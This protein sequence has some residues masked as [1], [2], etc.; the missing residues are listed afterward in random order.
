MEFKQTRIPIGKLSLNSG[1]IEGLPANPRQWKKD[2]ITRTAKS[3]QETPELFEMRPIIAV[4]WENTNIILAGSL[5]YCGAKEN[6][7]KQVPVILLPQDTAVEKL[8]EIVIKDNGNFGKWDMDALANEWDFEQ[9]KEWGVDGLPDINVE[10]PDEFKDRFGKI[11]DENCLYP[12]VPEYDEHP[13]VFIILSRTKT[14]SNWLREKLGMQKMKSYKSDKVAKS[15]I[16][17]IEDLKDVL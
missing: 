3:L 4:P 1:Q 5:R 8:K 10:T 9:L 2:D 14:D 17:S 15:N 11:N 13:E 16:I 7:D 12:I 6:G